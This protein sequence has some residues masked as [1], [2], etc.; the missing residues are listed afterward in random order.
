MIDKT[1][2]CHWIAEKG[3][4]NHSN[5]P[6]TLIRIA[7]RSNEFVGPWGWYHSWNKT[8]KKEKVTCKNCKRTKDYLK[9]PAKR[10]GGK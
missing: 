9:S 10:K 6:K 3:S 5:M 1:T 7:C 8:T 2:P 4:K